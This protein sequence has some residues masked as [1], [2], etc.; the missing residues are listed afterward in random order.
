MAFLLRVSSDFNGRKDALCGCW[1]PFRRRT[2]D[3]ECHGADVGSFGRRFD[4]LPTV[5]SKT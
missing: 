1:V 3:Q 5:S 4:E 2:R